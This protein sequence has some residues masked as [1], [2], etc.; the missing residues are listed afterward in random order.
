M[1]RMHVLLS[2]LTSFPLEFMIFLKPTLP[3]NGKLVIFSSFNL[4]I[5]AEIPDYNHRASILD[6]SYLI[7]LSSF[8]E[9]LFKK[10]L[11]KGLFC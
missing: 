6:L 2:E 3:I 7:E 1:L 8:R 5:N 4:R 9:Y 11:Q 10:C